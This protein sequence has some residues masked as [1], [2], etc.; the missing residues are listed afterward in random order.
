MASIQRTLGWLLSSLGL[1]LLCCSLLLVP[2]GNLLAEGDD[3]NGSNPAPCA[4]PACDNG[5]GFKVTC[6]GTVGFAGTCGAAV[7]T[8][9]TCAGCSCN[10]IKGIPSNL[11]SA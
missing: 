1:A 10:P 2:T 9:N 7:P 4:S 5:C 6:P 11:H 8:G 3:P